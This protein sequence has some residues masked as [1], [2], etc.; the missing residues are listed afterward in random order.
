MKVKAFPKE[1][2]VR[3]YGV[4]NRHDACDIAF[5]FGRQ[6]AA[7]NDDLRDWRP[8]L[9]SLIASTP[10]DAEDVV[11]E[12]PEVDRIANTVDTMIRATRAAMGRD[13]VHD[14]DCGR[15]SC[16]RYLRGHK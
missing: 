11:S 7:N 3:V 6:V 16:P 4:H 5:E 12:G 8:E 15:D 13:T 10:E 2:I 1:K 9:V 14:E